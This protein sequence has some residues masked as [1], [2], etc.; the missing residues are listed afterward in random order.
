MKQ[1]EQLTQNGEYYS[2]LFTCPKCKHVERGN[3]QWD[4]K[5]LPFME[6]DYEK[7]P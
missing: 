5:K 1:G 4:G 3:F 7:N 6:K 2:D